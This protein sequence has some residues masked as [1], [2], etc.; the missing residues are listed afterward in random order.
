MTVIL[1]DF[2]TETGANRNENSVIASQCAHWRG[3]PYPSLRSNVSAKR[4][5]NVTHVNDN[6]LQQKAFLWAIIPQK[7]GFAIRKEP[8]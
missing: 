4:A 6:L 1:D 5:D 8:G 3:N 7:G 2:S